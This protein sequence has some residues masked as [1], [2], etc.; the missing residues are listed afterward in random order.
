MNLLQSIRKSRIDFSMSVV[1]EDDQQ[2]YESATDLVNK[3]VFYFLFI[4]FLRIPTHNRTRPRWKS[5][6]NFLW[7]IYNR[8]KDLVFILI[9][10]MTL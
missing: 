2:A 8:Q 3:R 10:C 6:N 5:Q 4:I 1:L 9:S 7:Y